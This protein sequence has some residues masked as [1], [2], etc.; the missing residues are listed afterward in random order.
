VAAFPREKIE[1][2]MTFRKEIF[3]EVGEAV[4]LGMQADH[5]V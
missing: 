1:R 4:H 3:V 5:P 2:D